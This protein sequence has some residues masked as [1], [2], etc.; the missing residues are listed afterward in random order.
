MKTG[1]VKIATNPDMMSP[2]ATASHLG[3]SLKTLMRW[4]REGKGPTRARVGGRAY[5]YTPE[6]QDW[7]KDQFRAAS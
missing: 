6:V 3:L 5:Y 1:T 2:E 4:A 7:V